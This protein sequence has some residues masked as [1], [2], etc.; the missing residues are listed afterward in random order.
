MGLPKPS[1]LDI[2][3]VVEHYG[4]EAPV[5]GGA[6]GVKMRCFLPGHYDSQPSASLYEEKGYYRCFT[7]DVSLDGYGL[8]MK[9]ESCDFPSAITHGVEKFGGSNRAVPGAAAKPRR[10]APL[11][12]SERGAG[13]GSPDHH[14]L[15]TGSRARRKRIA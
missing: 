12:L 8:I 1:K 3:A 9:M 2:R 10:R 15:P 7:C 6:R 4:G 13:S 14:A 11:R 5:M